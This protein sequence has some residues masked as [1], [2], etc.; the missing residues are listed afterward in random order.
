MQNPSPNFRSNSHGLP[1]QPK[2][3]LQHENRRYILLRSPL[4]RQAD[5]KGGINLQEL[6][7]QEKR[8]TE[9]LRTQ[10]MLRAEYEK[11][12]CELYENICELEQNQKDETVQLKNLC[13]QFSHLEIEDRKDIRYSRKDE[14][15]KSCFQI[16]G[17]ETIR[18]GKH[19][20]ACMLRKIW[21][22]HL[23]LNQNK[24]EYEKEIQRL[25]TSLQSQETQIKEL[26]QKCTVLQNETESIRSNIIKYKESEKNKQIQL[27]AAEN[28]N[29]KLEKEIRENT[30]EIEKIKDEKQ[31]L[32]YEVDSLKKR[33]RDLEADNNIYKTLHH[34]LDSEMAK[35]NGSYKP[36]KTKDVQ[37]QCEYVFSMDNPNLTAREIDKMPGS[38]NGQLQI[39]EKK[40][41]ELK[42]E[43]GKHIKEIAVLRDQSVSQRS[44]K[45]YGVL[46][47]DVSKHTNEIE[48]KK[49]IQRLRDELEDTR[50]R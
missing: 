14:Q 33:C 9:K 41:S 35:R 39:L 29:R 5:K 19:T 34:T 30:E 50:I 27:T 46:Q 3:N 16:K 2:Y 24:N 36:Q 13:I 32:Y 26:R 31:K 20:V 6:K 22:R 49:E 28:R 23:R 44:D 38:Y 7:D 25:R 1:H 15:V 8:M 18:T 17:E 37:V 45:E 48:D 43:K 42:R 21:D 47:R 10:E 12:I 11:V 40:C 4:T